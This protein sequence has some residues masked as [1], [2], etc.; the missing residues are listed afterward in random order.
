[1]KH[2]PMLNIMENQQSY[3]EGNLA[4]FNATALSMHLEIGQVSLSALNE[5]EYYTYLYLLGKILLV[6]AYTPWRVFE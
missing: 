2:T 3:F 1:M 5:V 4:V 6:L